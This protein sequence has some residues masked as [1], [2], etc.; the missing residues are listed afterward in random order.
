V[1][2]LNL[3]RSDPEVRGAPGRGSNRIERIESSRLSQRV[4]ECLIRS[5]QV[6]RCESIAN[7]SVRT[8]FSRHRMNEENVMRMLGS[9]NH[10]QQSVAGQGPHQPKRGARNRNDHEYAMKKTFINGA[11]ALLVLAYP[12]YVSAQ[13]VPAAVAAGK[14]EQSHQQTAETSYMAENRAA[15]NK[16]MKDMEVKPSG[17]VDADFTAMMIP[18]HQGAV[19]MAEAEL[20]YGHDKK[21]RRIAR[22][23]VAG[24]RRQ[25]GAMRAALGQPLSEAT[26]SALPPGRSSSQTDARSAHNTAR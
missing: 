16:M 17:N 4:A 7:F 21:L 18:H 12:A 22:N 14:A 13:Q 20:H 9:N 5:V 23:I 11:L 3:R 24:Q 8:D 10:R 6:L 2:G 1:F 15:M 26:S 25:I 19:D